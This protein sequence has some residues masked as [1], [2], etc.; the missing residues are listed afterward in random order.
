M[1][2][3][4]N[5]EMTGETWNPI[6]GCTKI[7]PGCK[8]CYA[9]R[10]ALRL[11][12]I[13]QPKYAD[14]FRVALHEDALARPHKWKRPRR[15]FVNSMSDL[16]HDDVP[17]DFILRVFDVM[18]A[19][20]QHTYM[21]LTKRAERLSLMDPVLPW[22]EHIWMG[23]T[24]ENADYTWRVE[25]LRATGAHVKFLSLEPLLGPIPD[26]DLTGIDWVTT[27]GES[28]PRARAMEA[29]WATGVRDQCREQGVC[30]TFNGWGD[31]GGRTRGRVLEG[32]LYGEMPPTL[33]RPS[34]R[35]PTDAPL[36][37]LLPM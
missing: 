18:H 31:A 35:P 36:Q 15:V 13:G 33:A 28:G 12:A 6:T 16:L 24:V 14:G 32:R 3:R 21:A 7:S 19:A 4:A 29:A 34:Q 10:I 8:H 20:R 22:A 2:E 25:H 27:G 17:D 9:E 23:V 26:L 37:L 5:I 11:Q 1:A 30:F